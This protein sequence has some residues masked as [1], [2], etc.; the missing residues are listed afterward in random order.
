MGVL[1]FFG[2]LIKNDITSTS[3]NSNFKEKTMVNHLLLDFNSIVHVSSQK[4]LADV[5]VFMQLILKNI[6]EKRSIG[7]LA[8]TEKFEKYKMEHMQKKNNPKY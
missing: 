3:I 1:E 6:Y 4:I 5:N 8:F 2:T 7:G